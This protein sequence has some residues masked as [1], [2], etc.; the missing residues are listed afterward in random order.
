MESL[1][2]PTA[3]AQDEQQAHTTLISDWGWALFGS[4][5]TLG[6]RG[7]LGDSFLIV[8]QQSCQWVF[9]VS[10]PEGKAQVRLRALFRKTSPTPCWRGG[11]HSRGGF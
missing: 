1:V 2:G 6:L 7:L 5:F 9:Q 10:R 11:Y 4:H 3:S 8:G